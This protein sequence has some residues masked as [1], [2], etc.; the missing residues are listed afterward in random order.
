[1]RQ[2]VGLLR[3]GGT[4]GSPAIEGRPGAGGPEGYLPTPGLEDLGELVSKSNEEFTLTE[5]GDRPAV[6]QALGLSVYR[7]VQESLTNVLKHAGHG[8]RAAV[9]VTYARHGIGIRVVDDGAA[10][11]ALLQSPGDAGHGLRG[12][13]ERVAIHGGTFA[14]HPRPAGGFEVLAWLPYPPTDSRQLNGQPVRQ[15]DNQADSQ[16]INQAANRPMGTRA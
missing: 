6:S 8:A 4:P 1:M 13:W 15:A 10:S 7:I 2:M 16:A 11:P 3:S 9:G 5:Y 12:M 14:A